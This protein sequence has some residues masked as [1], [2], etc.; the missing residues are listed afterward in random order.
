MPW[1]TAKPK[2]MKKNLEIRLREAFAGVPAIGRFEAC[3]RTMI[4]RETQNPNKSV[5]PSA[6]NAMRSLRSIEIDP[7]LAYL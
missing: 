6:D 4:T 7:A 3:E 5:M 1:Q 2:R